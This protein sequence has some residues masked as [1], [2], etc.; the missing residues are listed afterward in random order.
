MTSRGG[1]G[2]WYV[3]L[4]ECADGTL[5]T[6]VAID[7]EARVACHNLGKGAKYTCGRRPVRLL[8]QERFGGQGEALRREHEIKQLP[9]R[10]K[11]ALVSC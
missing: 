3:Y 10:R 5:Y 6:G 9:R 11:W 2:A 1:D 4:V 8:Y 7:V